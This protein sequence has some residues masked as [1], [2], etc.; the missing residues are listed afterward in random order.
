MIKILRRFVPQYFGSNNLVYSLR[1][2]SCI[3]CASK[4]ENIICSA[5]VGKSHEKEDDIVS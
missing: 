3:F 2:I 4:Y 5:L 1:L